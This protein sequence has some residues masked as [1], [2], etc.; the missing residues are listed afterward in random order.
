MQLAAARTRLGVRVWAQRLLDIVRGCERSTAS[1]RKPL[2]CIAARRICTVQRAINR[3]ASRPGRQVSARA[4]AGSPVPMLL[5][6]EAQ[7]QFL[8]GLKSFAD[9]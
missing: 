8:R 7:E 4:C 6:N 5:D 3:R 1:H 9:E 2:R